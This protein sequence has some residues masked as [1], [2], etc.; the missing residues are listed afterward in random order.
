VIARGGGDPRSPKKLISR[1]AALKVAISG[2]GAIGGDGAVKLA[3]AGEDVTFTFAAGEP[4]GD[5]AARN[6]N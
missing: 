1:S 6:E 4:H 2:A 5:P 3:L